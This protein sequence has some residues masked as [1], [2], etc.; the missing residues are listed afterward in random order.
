MLIS[1]RMYS[2]D[3]K[4][5]LY[6][7][8]RGDIILYPTDTIWGIGCDAT[9]NNVVEKIFKIKNRA[10]TKSFIVLVDSFQMLK[11]Y[12]KHVPD[13][14]EELLKGFGTPV[15]VIY[16]NARKLAANV[17]APDN[18][19]AIRIINDDF[20]NPLIKKFGK[21]IVSTSANIS[22]QSTP[23]VFSHIDQTIIDEVDYVV[24]CKRD[25]FVSIKPS[26][27]IRLRDDGSYVIIRR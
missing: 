7:L 10:E 27:I 18:T 25:L 15:T 22:G 3:I 8:K 5:A 26:T 13:I 19:V 9:K 1:P 6:H 2:E 16:S 17:I 4:N 20:C 23:L 14:A 11:Q 21:P 12:V 24:G